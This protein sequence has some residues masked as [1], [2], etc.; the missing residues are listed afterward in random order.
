LD[1]AWRVKSAQQQWGKEIFI[2]FLV[3]RQHEGTKKDTAEWTVTAVKAVP[4]ERPTGNQGIIE[5]DLQKEK[6]DQK[7][8]AFVRGINEYRN[9]VGL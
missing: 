7:L 6:L 5:M 4:K 9:N 3:D 8:E 2:L 1:E